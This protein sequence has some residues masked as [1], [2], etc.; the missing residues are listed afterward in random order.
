M[1]S[2]QTEPGRALD[3][4]R[5]LT[6][7]QSLQAKSASDAAFGDPPLEPYYTVQQVAQM[8]G[9]HPTTVRRMFQDQPGV[10]RLGRTDRRDGKRPYTTMR[11]SKSALKRR[12]EEMSRA[13]ALGARSRKR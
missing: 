5:P 4:N 9:L 7:G 6:G 11:I 12:V 10:F 2:A 3:L 8:L 1:D 13:P